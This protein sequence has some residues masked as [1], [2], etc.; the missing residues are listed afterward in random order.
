MVSSFIKASE[1]SIQNAELFLYHVL[2]LQEKL[3]V[4]YLELG[5]KI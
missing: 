4:F 3:Y 5:H 1:Q 2:I